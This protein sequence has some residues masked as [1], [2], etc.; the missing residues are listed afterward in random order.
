MSEQPVVAERSDEIAY[1]LRAAEA[2][3]WTGSRLAIGIAAFAFASLAFAYFYLRSLNSENLWRPHD[4]T[5]PTGT[6][7]AVMA[8]TLAAAVMCVFASRRLRQGIHM[9]WQVAGWTAVLSGL[10]AV[11]L[12]I[13]QLTDL[14]FFP[15]TSGYSSCFI[16]WASL[17]IAVLLSGTYWI[18]TLL[19]RSLRLSRALAEEG[20]TA[21]SPLPVARLLRA[22][23][24]GAVYFWGFIALVAVL[25][26][27]LFY[28]I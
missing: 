23:V 10:L 6:G 14:H 2:S 16:G 21:D 18:E 12:Q 11:A 8:F 24:E 19:A 15:G 9:H 1:E 3:L 20:G 5:A 27:L 13:W 7:A 22:N 4:I 17:N 26:W 25:F 28:V